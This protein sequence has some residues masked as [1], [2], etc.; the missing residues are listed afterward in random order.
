MESQ[1]HSNAKGMLTILKNQKRLDYF[2]NYSGRSKEKKCV[3]PYAVKNVERQLGKVVVNILKRHLRA[4]LTP[5]FASA[6]L[7]FHPGF[8]ETKV[9]DLYT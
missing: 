1:S 6:I 2:Q 8:L 9:L 4:S 3:A 5:S 7:I